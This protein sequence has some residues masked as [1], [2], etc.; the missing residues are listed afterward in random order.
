[1][2]DSMNPGDDLASAVA[3]ASRLWLDYHEQLE[4]RRVSPEVE[5]EALER[6]FRGTLG[7]DGVGLETAVAEFRD[8]VLPASM[9]TPHPLYCGLINSSPLPGGS[10]ADL[11][12]STL[13]NNGGAFHQSPAITA[14]ETEVL[15]V[16]SELFG[17]T[18]CGGM[19]V[20]GG[21]FAT[22]QGLLLAR[23]QQF[24]QARRT[25]ITAEIR[26]RLYTG[27]SHH[28]S[29]SRAAQVIG[30]GEDNVVPIP[31]RDRGELD[32]DQLEQAVKEDRAAGARPFAVVATLGTTGT[33]ALDPIEPIAELCEREGIWLHVDACYG[34]AAALLDEFAGAFAGVD[35]A[36]SIAVDPHKW[37]FIPMTAG[38]LLTRH[39]QVEHS[40]FDLDAS[41]IPGDGR[42]AYRRGI[43][44][45]RRASALTIWMALRA[46][47]LSTV[48]DA[49]AR[50]CSAARHLEQDLRCRGFRVLEG[51]R[52]SIA[53]ARWEPDGLSEDELDTLQDRIA[54]A[55][56][57]SGRTW[58][59]TVRHAGRT[60]LR[61]C[62]LNLYTRDSHM[63]ELA[64]L[65]EGIA[66]EIR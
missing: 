39:A 64:E 57:A 42:D 10:L 50:N 58:F 41:Y 6:Q 48:R 29:V 17:L 59:A 33:G 11:F 62:M 3:A 63:D 20:P 40:S 8:L 1:M 60:W 38:L 47:G 44:T 32:V 37:F 53:C 25:G 45:S 27:A 54:R 34:G 65:V 56:V 36:D 55:A 7:V 30:L 46:H 15:R 35:R 12:V 16:F 51:G 5:R 61:F 22:L 2:T 4:D 9:A 23:T 28:F 24:P 66:R 18:D 13:N 43:P 49:V 26:P 31:G 52:L 21:S 19:I 14:L